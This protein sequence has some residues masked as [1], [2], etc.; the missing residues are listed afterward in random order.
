MIGSSHSQ[1][2]KK[3]SCSVKF[4]GGLLDHNPRKILVENSW[5]I[6]LQNNSKSLFSNDKQ[7]PHEILFSLLQKQSSGRVLRDFAKFTGK[8]LR[9]S[10]FF[11]KVAGLRPTTL[12]KKSLWRRCFPVNFAKFLRTPFTQNTSDGCFCC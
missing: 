4:Q 11:N 5:I 12:L 9:Q 1:L 3:K 6:I 2:R 7:M 10:F 8:H